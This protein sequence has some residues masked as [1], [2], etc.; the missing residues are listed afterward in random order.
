VER[1]DA[2]A[3][4][5]KIERS[6]A[7]SFPIAGEKEEDEAGADKIAKRL[8]FWKKKKEKNNNSE[9]TEERV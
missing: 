2:W 9:G 4:R 7:T 8:Q 3:E 6:S 1:N 5:K